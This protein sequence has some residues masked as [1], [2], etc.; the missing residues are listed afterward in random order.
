[1]ASL[2]SDCSKRLV[3]WS[4]Q[5][6]HRQ[7]FLNCQL[8][9][10]VIQCRCPACPLYPMLE[11][12]ADDSDACIAWLAVALRLA[13]LMTTLKLHTH[14]QSHGVSF[15]L[16]LAQALWSMRTLSTLTLPPFNAELLAAA[17][18]FT[19]LMLLTDTLPYAFFDD[20]FACAQLTPHTAPLVGSP[21]CAQGA[22]YS[23]ATPFCARWQYCPCCHPCSWWVGWRLLA[24]WHT[25]AL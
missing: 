18:G 5:Y 8:G 3:N 11:L 14:T 10:K 7:T 1:M 17:P 6:G 16:V 22:I 24:N 13:E 2:A 15:E 21:C 19:H 20:F 12:S 23:H 9:I 25:N 4:G